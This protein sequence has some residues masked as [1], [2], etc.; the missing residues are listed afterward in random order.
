MCVL[1]FTR[2]IQRERPQLDAYPI[3]HLNRGPNIQVSDKVFCNWR[4]MYASWILGPDQGRGHYGI[5]AKWSILR[6]SS[7]RSD[8]KRLT[9]RFYQYIKIFKIKVNISAFLAAWMFDNKP[10]ILKIG[11]RGYCTPG[12]YF[13]RLC[14][15]SQK[16]N[17]L[18]TKYPMDLVRNVP[19]NSEITVLLT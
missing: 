5:F 13:W 9:C 17:N 14:A 12:P 3:M 8:L 18:W 1:A 19:R 16:V 6:G 2:L 4:F 7:P 10:Y 11:L 15:F